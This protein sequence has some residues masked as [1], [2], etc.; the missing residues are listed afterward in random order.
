MAY[1]RTDEIV[2]WFFRGR[3]E[4][5]V[6]QNVYDVLEPGRVV[7]DRLQCYEEEHMHKT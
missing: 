6:W 4:R 5:S 2:E 3:K 1:T 7:Q